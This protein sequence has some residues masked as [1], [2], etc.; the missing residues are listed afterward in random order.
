M[1]EIN[2]ADRVFRDAKGAG[3]THFLRVEIGELCEITK[4]ELEEGL[5]KVTQARVVDSLQDYGGSVLQRSGDVGDF[6]VSNWEFKVDFVESKI[7]CSCGYGGRAKILDSGHGY[8]LYGCPS[9]EGSGKD[10]KVL[11]GGE[12]RVV[13][14]E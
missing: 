7:K 2:I 10:V 5:G 12:I 14:I 6:E 9:C 13:E 3:A 8:C 1:H 11:E 4:E